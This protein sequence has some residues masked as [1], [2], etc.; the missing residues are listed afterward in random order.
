MGYVVSQALEVVEYY[1]AYR[2]GQFDLMPQ[3][4]SSCGREV[5]PYPGLTSPVERSH[6]LQDW[7]ALRVD[8]RVLR[9]EMEGRRPARRLCSRRTP[10]RLSAHRD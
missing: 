6:Y 3:G 8:E 1:L 7:H 5:L 10:R 9:Q 2:V 4:Q